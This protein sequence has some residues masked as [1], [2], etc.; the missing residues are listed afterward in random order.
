MKQRA[1]RVKTRHIILAVMC[2]MYFISYIDRVNIGFAALRN[3][4]G[5]R[6]VVA[7]MPDRCGEEI[8]QLAPGVA[9]RAVRHPHRRAVIGA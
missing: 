5:E 3:D 8:V 4:V 7:W 1:Q 2:L 9:R 6:N